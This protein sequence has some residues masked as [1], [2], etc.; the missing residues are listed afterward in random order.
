[1][2]LQIGSKYRQIPGKNWE[3]PGKFQKDAD[4]ATSPQMQQISQ[5]EFSRGMNMRV[6]D[7]PPP[8]IVDL[9][10]LE[11]EQVSLSVF[12]SGIALEQSGKVKRNS[13]YPWKFTVSGD[14]HTDGTNLYFVDLSTYEC[15]CLYFTNTHKTCKH[16]VAALVSLGDEVLSLV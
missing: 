2:V 1:M 16:L 6:I 14:S 15:G 9:T 12:H 4:M 7:S 11:N 8:R 3:N 13:L 10:T 5:T